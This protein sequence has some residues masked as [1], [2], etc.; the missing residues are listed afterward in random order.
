MFLCFC[1]FAL[2]RAQ[3]SH[4]SELEASL[5]SL[6]AARQYCQVEPEAPFEEGGGDAVDDSWPLAGDISFREVCVPASEGGSN[7]N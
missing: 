7:A 5:P 2:T 3:V 1:V 6:D 4:W